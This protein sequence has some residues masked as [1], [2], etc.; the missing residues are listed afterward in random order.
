MKVIQRLPGFIGISVF[1]ILFSASCYA[2][3]LLRDFTLPIPLFSND[4]P[5]NDTISRAA[6]ISASDTQILTLYHVLRGDISSLQPK[7]TSPATTWPFMDISYDS[8]AIPIFKTGTGSQS[9]SMYDYNGSPAQ[10][11]PKIQANPDGTVTVPSSS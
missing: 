2:D 1:F 8:Y 11:T 5:W 10:N 9:V 3:S 4:S 7:Q 6:V